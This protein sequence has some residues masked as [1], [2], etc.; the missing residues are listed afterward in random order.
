MRSHAELFAALAVPRLV[1]TANHGRVRDLL[2]HEL[3]RRG[4]VV[5]EHRFAAAPRF[6]LWGAPVAEGINLIA[7][8]P[9][10]RVTTWLVAHYDSKGQPVSMA[11]RLLLVGAAL[12]AL[13][14]AAVA[15]MGGGHPIVWWAPPIGLA[16]LMVWLNRVTERSPGA[17]DNASGVLTALTALDALS[18]RTTVGVL[19]LDAEEFGLVGARALVRERQNLLHDTVVINFDGIDDRGGVVAFVHRPG[20]VVNAVA[21][22]LRARRCQRL[23]VLVDGMALAAAARECVTLMKGDWGT[24]RIVHRP[25][26]SQDRLVLGGVSEVGRGVAEALED[27]H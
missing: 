11:T 27:I 25:G 15:T 6:P 1:G 14:A 23:P 8:R 21:E 4:F 18:P 13:V 5:L 7:V 16:G 9:R 12:A 22:R 24:M 3:V 26:D 19:L 2:K 17:V 10:T 20:P